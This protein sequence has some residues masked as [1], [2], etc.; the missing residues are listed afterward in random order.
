MA[1]ITVR[2][3]H[4]G[5][6]C[7]SPALPFGGENKN[8]LKLSPIMTRRSERLWLPVSAYLIEHPKG[9]V[10]VDCGW[11]RNM[12][13]Q[14]KY[15]KSAQIRSLG[16]RALYMVNQGKLEKG[17]AID[18]QLA[19]IG[20]RP[21]DLDYVLLSHLDCDHV[22]G[23]ALVKDA[24]HIWV[25]EDELIG[26]KKKTRKNKIRYQNK[27]WDGCDLKGFDWNDEEGPFG[28]A[29]DLFGDG[30]L[31]MIAIPG[32]SDGLCAVKVKNE[33]GKFVLLFSDGGYADRSWQEMILPGV[34]VDKDAQRKSL[35]WI[36]EQSMHEDCLESVSNHD[37]DVKPH[38][39]YL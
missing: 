26:A 8:P 21:V 38:C 5:S 2:I 35:A 12:S 11:H 33:D 9:K 1:N 14:G 4:T 25:S 19:E 16:S 6:V 13:P 32:H 17:Q 37:A 27:W 31:K 20:I 39:I 23:L 7:V 28:K 18:E 30:S 22:N 10:L 34:C 24:K 3:F 15:D 36:R 29:F